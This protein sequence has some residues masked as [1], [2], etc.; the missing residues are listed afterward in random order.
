MKCEYDIQGVCPSKVSF[1][2]DTDANTI[3][4]IS[5]DGGCSGNLSAIAKL[6]EGESPDKVIEMFAGHTCGR[7][8]TS[9][10]DQLAKAVQNARENNN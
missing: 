6:L 4:G 2:L 8:C 3:S 10:V 7:K 9:C 5:F 1:E